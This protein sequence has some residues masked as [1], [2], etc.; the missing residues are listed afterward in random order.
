MRASDAVCHSKSA[1]SF[2]HPAVSSAPPAFSARQAFADAAVAVPGAFALEAECAAADV[3]LA[4]ES[5]DVPLA[6]CV[7]AVP[8]DD[9]VADDCLVAPQADGR[10]TPAALPDDCSAPVDLAV[11][12]L[13]AADYWAAL[14]V[15]GR[16]P[17]AAPPDDCLAPVDSAADDSVAA[18][19]S[20][21]LK[22][23][24]RSAPAVLPDDCSAPVDWAADDLV[25]ADCSERADSVAGDLHPAARSAQL[26]SPVRSQDSCRVAQRSLWRVFQEALA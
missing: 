10:S 18:D 12:G 16:S 7:A 20:V 26:D 1:K 17:P 15:D 14:K 13:V 3:R 6:L 25:A 19:C 9:S 22:A 2:T 21:A 23:A 8:R 24:D 4:E 5:K 11:A